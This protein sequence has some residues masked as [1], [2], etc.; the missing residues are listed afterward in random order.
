[1]TGFASLQKFHR[2]SINHSYIAL[3]AIIALFCVSGVYGQ[4]WMVSNDWTRYQHIRTAT[5]TYSGSATAAMPFIGQH[6]DLVINPGNASWRNTLRSENPNIKLIKY[7]TLSSIRS[8]DVSLIPGF[9]ADSGYIADSL[10]LW[11]SGDSAVVYGSGPGCNADIRRSYRG[12]KLGFCGWT[13]QRYAADFRYEGTPAYFRWKALNEMGAEWDGVMEDEAHFYTG[14]N[15]MMFPFRNTGGDDTKW[16][17]G[18]TVS[19]IKGWEGYTWLQARNELQQIRINTS[20]GSGW[21]KDF[22]DAMY[23]ANKMH[24]ANVTNYGAI[25]SATDPW[26]GTW[27]AGM[28]G[29]IF[30][31]AASP[32]IYTWSSSVWDYM[33][34]IVVWDTGYAVVW[35]TIFDGGASEVV[36][37]GSLERCQM[38]R[39]TFYYMAANP[40]RFFFMLCGNTIEH[41]PNDFM[42]AD[43]SFKWFGAI[44][45]NIGTPTA[46]RYVVASG[47]DPAGQNYNLY[48]RDYTNSLMLYRMRGGSNYGNPS[49]VSY[50]LGGSFQELYADGTLGPIVSSATI[51][52]VEGKIFIPEGS[53]IIDT[54]PPD[55]IDDLGNNNPDSSQSQAMASAEPHF[56][57]NPFDMTFTPTTT[58]TGFQDEGT[59][60][61]MTPTGDVVKSWDNITGQDIF[62]DGTNIE[63]SEVASS[64]YLW[65]LAGTNFKG[66]LVVV[67]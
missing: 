23:G 25:T 44:E 10:Y 55:S 36:S 34:S 53:N 62:W 33:D 18:T 49:G 63:G 21:L 50:N 48:R 41:R 6:Y 32:I 65:Y 26:H 54:I 42:M 51:R 5:I 15:H 14:A 16:I 19:D 11:V 28:G 24:L 64:V 46:P 58:F 61:L 7:L 45:Y 56:Y 20:D 9:C 38:E 37:L 40:E 27:K 67:N 22:E 17:E 1:M 31:N 29:F 60:V 59:L 66:K 57:P 43:T 13:E 35:L 2:E 12:E 47:T 52:N 39:L 3:I 30:E 8:G 4:T